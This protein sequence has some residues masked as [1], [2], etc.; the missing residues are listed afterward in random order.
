MT[1]DSRIR[2]VIGSR[3]AMAREAV[4]Y[5]IAEA[6]KLLGFKNYQTLSAI[7]RGSRNINAHELSA[8]ADLYG[9]NL[10]YFFNDEIT[11]DPKPLWRKISP[12]TDEKHAQ[13]AFLSFLENY[14][15]ME[16]LLNLRRRWIDLQ[17][18]YSKS[19]FS[20]RGFDLANQLGNET[21]QSLDLGSR[22]AANLLNILENNLRVKILHLTLENGISGASVVD[23]KLGVGILINAS[24]AP[25][26]RSF[27]LAHELFHIVTWNVFT[28]REV[29]DGT[30]RTL[31]EKYADAFA[32]S[33][34]LPETH[35]RSILSDI[36]IDNKIRIVDIIELAK[37]FGVST[38]AILWRLVNLN[39]IEKS[40][41]DQT[42]GDSRFRGIDRE[43]RKGLY[44][45]NIPPKYPERYISIACRCLLE[46]IVSRGMFAKYLDIDRAHVDCFLE[47]HG[48]L[49][50]NYEKIAAT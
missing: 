26:R 48:F 16:N 37:E 17:R 19:D 13:R 22:P 45:E 42:L 44:F 34:L 12:E 14:S 27:D 24:D 9:R 32:S 41:V 30:K 35:I 15:N 21:R 49:D 11:T 29:G 28:P 5:S 18:N 7:E 36:I 2:N 20:A 31:P 46:G 40:I 6:S 1:S 47:E 33:L 25:W 39:I 43:L 3:V 10:D 23:N 38:E 8:M 50:K 4:G